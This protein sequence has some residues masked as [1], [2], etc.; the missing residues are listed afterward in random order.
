MLLRKIEA[1]A[2]RTSRAS[3]GFDKDDRKYD[4]TDRILLSGTIQPT[5]KE[6]ENRKKM[7]SS[8]CSVERINSFS[9]SFSIHIRY[10]KALAFR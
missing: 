10:E 2:R 8:N 5:R 3:F 6:I 9:S 1:M 4:A 7:R